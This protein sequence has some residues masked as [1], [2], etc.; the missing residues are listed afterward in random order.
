MIVFLLPSQGVNELR[1]HKVI[2]FGASRSRIVL[3]IHVC[4][5]LRLI[6]FSSDVVIQ[7]P[8]RKS[9]VSTTRTLFL[10]FCQTK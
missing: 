6:S 1:H 7:Y 2:N 5:F 8:I 10:V 9:G 4:L 3:W